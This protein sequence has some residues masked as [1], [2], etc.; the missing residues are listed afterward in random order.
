[1]IK[2]LTIY[3]ILL[4]GF[5]SC[6]TYKTFYKTTKS[7][8]DSNTSKAKIYRFN[9]KTYNFN[10]A[11]DNLRQ[12]KDLR[13]LNL[14]GTTKNVDTLNLLLNEIPNPKQLQ[15]LILDSLD[16]TTLP[17]A[18]QRFTH[19]KQLSLNNNPQL[20]LDKV[21]TD[22][23]D[24]PIAFLNLQHNHLTKLPASIQYIETLVDL[25]LSRNNLTDTK[26]F[27]YLAQLDRLRSLWL[28]D[29]NLTALPNTIS[30]LH[31]LRN[32]YFEHNNV[33]NLPKD[34]Y[35]MKK[36]W[37]IHAGHNKFN[38]L[39][40]Q[41]SKMKA[42]LLLHINNCNISEIPEAFNS[43]KISLFGLIIDNNNISEADKIK[44]QKTFRKFFILSME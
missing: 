3:F 14:S 39:P 24:L 35:K 26:T 40:E 1:M 16:L 5:N 8:I 29:N 32:L 6:N 31:Q 19:L 27:T 23:K 30:Q 17:I 10:I 28:N 2:K 34:F 13:M 44:W 36:V 9:F 7:T 38:S 12:L 11:K 22:L 42:L 21:F 37:V 41:F 33:E 43:K 18:I 20:N 25:N 15:V 4:I